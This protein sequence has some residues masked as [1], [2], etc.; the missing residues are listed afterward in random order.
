MVGLP[1]ATAENARKK[2]KQNIADILLSYGFYI[3][4]LGIIL[5]FAFKDEKFLTLGNLFN[6][7]T[8]AV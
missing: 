4:I 8:Q 3:A 2:G 1:A 5:I 7:V 6:V